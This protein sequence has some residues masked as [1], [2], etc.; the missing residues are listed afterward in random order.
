MRKGIYD[1]INTD[2]KLYRNKELLNDFAHICDVHCCDGRSQKMKKN[3][4]E[5]FL[6]V[7]CVRFELAECPHLTTIMRK[8]R[9]YISILTVRPAR[10]RHKRY[11]IRFICICFIRFDQWCRRGRKLAKILPKIFNRTS[12]LTYSYCVRHFA[13]DWMSQ[14]IEHWRRQMQK[15]CNSII[16]SLDRNIKE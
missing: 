16:D 10:L 12:I 6:W 7:S 5:T 11:W 13:I 8:D 15:K 2:L 9:S 4:G 3:R 14:S 1:I